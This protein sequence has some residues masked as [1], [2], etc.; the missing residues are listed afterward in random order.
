MHLVRGSCYIF[1]APSNCFV[2]I[3]KGEIV[4]LNSYLLMIT[5]QLDVSNTFCRD[6][7]QKWTKQVCGFK[8]EKEDQKE[9]R[10]LRMMS[11]AQKE[12]IGRP[13]SFEH[14]RTSK[15][16]RL[17]R[18]KK[19][20]QELLDYWSG[21]DAQHLCIGRPTSVAALRTQHS[22]RIGRPKDFK[23]TSRTHWS[24]SDA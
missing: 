6:P 13:I 10:L 1:F 12:S 22:E 7:F 15:E 20:S 9:W 16:L 3:K 4:Y 18:P 17:G 21:S 24:R 2:I 8:A 11:D 23:K 19:T 14:L 5:K